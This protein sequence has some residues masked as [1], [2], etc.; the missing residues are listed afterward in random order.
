MSVILLLCLGLAHMAFALLSGIAWRTYPAGLL[1]AVPFFIVWLKNRMGAGDVKLLMGIGLY[2]G[3]TNTLTA[4]VLMLPVLIVCMICSRQKGRE[5]K[6]AIPFA[7]VLAFGAS[8]T[9]LLGYSI[10][11]LN[12]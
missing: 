4:F 7:P 5:V 3:L 8:G 10:A 12:L 9:V 6:N 2:L 1:P 11:I